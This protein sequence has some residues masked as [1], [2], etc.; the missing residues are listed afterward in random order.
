MRKSIHSG[1]NEAKSEALGKILT[2]VDYE[3]K[4]SEVSINRF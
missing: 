2:Q 1:T 4:G 3:F